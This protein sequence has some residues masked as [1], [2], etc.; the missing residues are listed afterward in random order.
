MW[1]I[2][3]EEFFPLATLISKSPYRTTQ[4]SNLHALDPAFCVHQPAEL[5][6]SLALLVRHLILVSVTFVQSTSS[7]R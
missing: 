4:V 3:S 2:T 6:N 1:L 5:S 7:F